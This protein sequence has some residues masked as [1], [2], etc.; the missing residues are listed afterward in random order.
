MNTLGHGFWWCVAAFCIVWYSTVTIW[1]A[2]KG[3]TDIRAMLARL[4]R[5]GPGRE[6]ER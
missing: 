1:V 5:S 4:A 3:A 2:V 6:R